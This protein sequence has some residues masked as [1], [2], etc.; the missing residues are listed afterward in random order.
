MLRELMISK[1]ESINNHEG[2]AI[3]SLECVYTGDNGDV[4]YN[5]HPARIFLFGLWY[6]KTGWNSDRK[7]IYYKTR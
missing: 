1:S 2:R 3:S 5:E 7:V 4:A 6:T